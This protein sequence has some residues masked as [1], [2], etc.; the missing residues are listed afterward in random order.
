MPGITDD[1][2]FDTIIHIT[3]GHYSG[4]QCLETGLIQPPRQ[5]LA[6]PSIIHHRTGKSCRRRTRNDSIE[7]PGKALRFREGLSAASRT[8]IKVRFRWRFAVITLNNDLSNQRY[9]M[10]AS[11]S[12]IELSLEV[13]VCPKR[14]VAVAPN[15]E[16]QQRIASGQP[17]PTSS[18]HHRQVVGPTKSTT[19]Q[20]QKLPIP[21]ELGQLHQKSN[22]G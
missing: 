1:P 5:P 13:I 18:R 22:S 2:I 21:I 17:I 3:V 12:E 20:F 10:W 15:S 11:N 4:V 14:A 19:S 7:I 16:Y 8:A 6:C 9:Y